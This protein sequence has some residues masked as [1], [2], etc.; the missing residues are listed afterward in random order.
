M[1]M[2]R[3]VCA[4]IVGMIQGLPWSKVRINR[5]PAIIPDRMVMYGECS[6]HLIVQ[7]VGEPGCLTL[8]K[9]MGS[10]RIIAI[11]IIRIRELRMTNRMSEQSKE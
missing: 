4:D 6:C 1:C 5:G 2:A 9:R 11:S 10:L 3:E 8:C 7:L